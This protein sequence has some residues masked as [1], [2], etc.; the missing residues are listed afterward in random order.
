MLNFINFVYN[1]LCY[2][3]NVFLKNATS[4]DEHSTSIDKGGNSDYTGNNR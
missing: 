4:I 3:S 2:I 1:C